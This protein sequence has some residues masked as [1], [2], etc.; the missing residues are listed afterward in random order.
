MARAVCDFSINDADVA[1]VDSRRCKGDDVGIPEEKAH[2]PEIQI[3]E[4][5]DKCF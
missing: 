4:S 2:V 3:K 5:C 1:F